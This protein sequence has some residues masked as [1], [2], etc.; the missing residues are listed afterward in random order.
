MKKETVITVKKLVKNYGKV[1]A[2]KGISFEVFD[3]EI[4]GFLGPN[5]AGKTTTLEI[6]ETLRKKTKGE[7]WVGGY[8]LD[9]SPNDI[10]SIIGVQLQSSGFYPN[11]K[12]TEILNL[13]AS[14]YGV[15]IDP[16]KLLRKVDLKD[17]AGTFVKKLSGVQ[18]QRF[19][20]ATTLVQDPAIIFFD[21]PS[22]GLDPQARRNLWTLIKEIN[23]KGTT[24]VLTTHFMDEAE[25]LCDRVAIMDKGKILK[26]NSPDNLIDELLA[27]GFKKVRKMREASLE[28]VFLELTGHKLRE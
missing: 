19:Y 14:L 3:G 23:K 15:S 27:N 2:V 11:L 26:I 17:K 9:K 12:L 24:V 18:E 4:F 13:F 1:K 21:E 10:K 16:L 7:V 20:L 6:V 8:N 5:G 28:D 25:Y 22:T